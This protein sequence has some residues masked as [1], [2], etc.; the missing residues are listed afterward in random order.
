M[1]IATPNFSLTLYSI[2]LG[3][4]YFLNPAFE[5]TVLWYTGSANY[6]WTTLIMLIAIYPAIKI[7]RNQKLG[8]QDYIL[9]LLSFLAGWGNENTSPTLLF[10][11]IV[12]LGMYVKKT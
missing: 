2:V 7:L 10:F 11:L 12:L 6:M 4:L 1:K 5:K 3:C 8:I 9:L